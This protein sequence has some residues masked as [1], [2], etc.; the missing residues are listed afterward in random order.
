MLGL[1]CVAATLAIA[2]AIGTPSDE[3][4]DRKPR[5]QNSVVEQEPFSGVNWDNV[6]DADRG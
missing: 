6:S 5:S 2:V 3:M 1:G 4:Y